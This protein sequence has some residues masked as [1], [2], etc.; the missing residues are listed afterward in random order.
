M[1]FLGM[2]LAGSWDTA[3]ELRDDDAPTYTLPAQRESVRQLIADLV[4]GAIQPE[5]VTAQHATL[6]VQVEEDRVLLHGGGVFIAIRRQATDPLVL[7]APHAFYD[8]RTGRIASQLF[9]EGVGQVLMVNTVHRY[10]GDR[11][12]EH[13]PADVAHSSSSTFQ[14]ATLGAAQGLGDG[15]VVQLHGFAD[16]EAYPSLAAVVSS[17]SA[18]QPPGLLDEAQRA[19]GVLGEVMTGDQMPDLA[20]TKNVQGRALS[21]TARFLHL[22]LSAKTRTELA[23]QSERR[24]EL[25]RILTELAR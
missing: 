4:S 19:L 20:G 23:E 13:E 17:G 5:S 6:T 9:D 3:K 16:R 11:G 1:M 24:Q 8:A 18:L 2:L 22:E 12:A 21:G 10:R 15:L 7:Q 25:G 14:A